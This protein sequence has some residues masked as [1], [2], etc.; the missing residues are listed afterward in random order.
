MG[1]RCEGDVAAGDTPPGSF[2]YTG[3]SE[4]SWWSLVCLCNS[5]SCPSHGDGD[6]ATVSENATL[7]TVVKRP[8]RPPP[9][10]SMSVLGN[11][12]GPPSFGRLG[13]ASVPGFPNVEM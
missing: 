9:G 8:R 7:E 1:A 12:I 5:L 4:C 2:K 6:E 10:G 13:L 3:C 11:L